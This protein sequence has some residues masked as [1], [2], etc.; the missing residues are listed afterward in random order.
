MIIVKKL[1]KTI[2]LLYTLNIV[3]S[4]IGKIVPINFYT[5]I[6]V[7]VFDFLGIL[8]I[9]YLK[10]FV[11]RRLFWIRYMIILKI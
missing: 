9:I 11:W 8:A 4:S 1:V 7:Y 10:Y 5:I 3:L 6:I 2:C